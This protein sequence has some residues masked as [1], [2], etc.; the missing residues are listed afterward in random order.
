[1]YEVRIAEQVLKRLKRLPSKHRRQVW[2]R[3][4]SLQES[5]RPQ[6]FRQL[7][8]IKGYRI[9]VGEYRIL[10]TIDDETRVVT[11]YLLFQRGEGYPR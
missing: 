4:R 7:R 3:I 9:T 2:E 11:I 6:D 1:M 10:Y 8:G 5:P